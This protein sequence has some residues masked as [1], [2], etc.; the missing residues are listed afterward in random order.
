MDVPT[1]EDLV[2]QDEGL[3]LTIYKDIEGIWT[4]GHGRNLEDVG[5]SAQEAEIL[6]SND[7]A[8]ARQEAE[9]FY[10]FDSLDNVRQLV[11]LSMLFQMGMTRFL[12]FDRMIIALRSGNYQTA[13]QE[14]INSLWAKQTPTRAQ[15]L[16]GWMKTGSVE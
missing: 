9:T 14:M 4:I 8:R 10:W 11:V 15:K 7:C 13:S 2:S 3:R 12:G 6:L 5:I 1:L 16:A